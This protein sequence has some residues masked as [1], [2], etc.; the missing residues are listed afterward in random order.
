MWNGKNTKIFTYN[1]KKKNIKMLTKLSMHIRKKWKNRK[2]DKNSHPYYINKKRWKQS[3]AVKTKQTCNEGSETFS[4]VDPIFSW[5]WLKANQ[6]SAF[7]VQITQLKILIA[8]FQYS[9]K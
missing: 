7:Q 2:Q 1:I 4:C 3:N 5:F 9:F 6:H 8:D